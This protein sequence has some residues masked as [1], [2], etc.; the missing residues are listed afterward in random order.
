M[1]PNNT[2]TD[3]YARHL[4]LPDFSQE[5]QARLKQKTA[6]L[7]GLGGLGGHIAPLLCAAGVGKLVLADADTV[8]LSNLQRQILYR[9]TQI[10]QSKAECAGLSLHALNSETHLEIHTEFLNEE[11]ALSIARDCDIIVDGSDNAKARYLMNDLAV[12]LGVPYVYGSICEYSGQVAVFNMDNDAP[13]YRCLFPETEGKADD[14]PRGVIGPLPAWVAAMQ[15]HECVRILSGLQPA[16]AGRLF[17]GSLLSMHTRV[18]QLQASGT[19]RK[20]SMERFAT[21]S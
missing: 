10:G 21:L 5:N 2:A 14:A 18:L 11:N 1:T 3:R 12:G 15:S 7:V 16:L 6:L 13:T 19:G 20:L 17:T 4:I 9:E 8:S